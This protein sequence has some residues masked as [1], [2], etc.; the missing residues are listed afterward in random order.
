MQKNPSH[1]YARPAWLWLAFFYHQYFDTQLALTTTFCRLCNTDQGGDGECDRDEDVWRGWRMGRHRSTK[2]SRGYWKQ[3]ILPQIRPTWPGQ[4][5]C[6]LTP[7]SSIH[8]IGGTCRTA[9]AERT[10]LGAL[11][12]YP[13]RKDPRLTN[14]PPYTKPPVLVCVTAQFQPC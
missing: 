1:E 3:L 11:M 7:Q 6:F 9:Q 12:H 2:M 4:F 8:F 5:F 10:K 14:N 13:E